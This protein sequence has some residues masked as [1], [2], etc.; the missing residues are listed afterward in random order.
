MMAWL[1]GKA[2]VLARRPLEN[3]EWKRHIVEV[4]PPLW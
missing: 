2:S 1:V 3:Q 4:M